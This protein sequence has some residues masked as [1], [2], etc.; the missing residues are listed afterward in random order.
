MFSV[1]SSRGEGVC[2]CLRMRKPAKALL[3]AV[4]V[5][6]G[7]IALTISAAFS[8]AIAYGAIALIV[9]GTG[10]PNANI[11]ENY[12][13]NIRDYYFQGTPCNSEANCGDSDLVG[14]NYPASFWPLAIF[15]SWCRSGPSGCDKWN[16]SVGQGADGGPLGP[17]LTDELNDALSTPSPT[18]GT[19]DIIIFGYSQGGAVVSKVLNEY[20]LTDE[21][22]RRIQVVTIGGIE[23]PDGGLWQR[24]AFLQYIP[25]L[26]V[27]FDP[28]MPVDPDLK[29]TT[30]GFEY[31]PVVYAPRYWGNPLA[32][33]NALAAFETVHGYYLEPNG[34]DTPG[35]PGSLPY[36]YTPDTLLE[37]LDCSESGHPE[38]CR[39]DQYDN[40]YIMIP[41][42][43]L[44]MYDLLLSLVPAQLRPLVK[45]FVELAT[46]VTKV[47]VDLG[48]DWSGDPGTPTPLSILPFNP[49]QNWF[50]VGGDLVG[51]SVEGVQRFIAALGELGGATAQQQ[52]ANENSIQAFSR[53]AGDELPKDKVA[54]EQQQDELPAAGGDEQMSPVIDNQ[55]GNV[56]VLKDP[57]T[58]LDAQA[59]AAQAA[60]AE[61]EAA[62]KAAEAEAAAKAAALAAANQP[63]LTPVTQVLVDDPIDQSGNGTTDKVTRVAD[64]PKD[65]PKRV[66]GP[67]AKAVKDAAGALKSVADKVKA[68]ADKLRQRAADNAKDGAGNDK[69]KVDD[70]NPTAPAEGA[71]DTEKAAA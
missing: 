27:T 46:P 30:I 71:A 65:A 9:P 12:R 8:A 49:F 15:P 63:V 17:G 54:I 18:P 50:K 11:V 62:A 39:Y 26:D 19:P 61:A 33:L 25:I 52:T 36:G 42:T 29:T 34:N 48:Y 69:P 13:E 3:V 41:A 28:P 64:A 20:G 44:P 4:V 31:D 22:Q 55:G 58:D 16:E 68:A 2:D 1:Q 7:S 37:Q 23:N 70:V 5:F 38:N 56:V 53:L 51:A 59:A 66:N 10:T 47:L 14:I 21:E 60:A 45:P 35:E 43:S 24:L 67:I 40:P 32:M 6:F 57:L